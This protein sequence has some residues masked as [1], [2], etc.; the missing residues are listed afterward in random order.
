MTE[1]KKT[2]KKTVTKAIATPK[3][4]AKA[5]IAV[6][7]DVYPAI[8]VAKIIGLSDFD[9]LTIKNKKG[10]NDGSL[11]SIAQMQEYYDEIIEGR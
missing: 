8:N 2:T 9:F 3:V 11:L 4:K 10:I 1:K 7:E 6:K 5:P